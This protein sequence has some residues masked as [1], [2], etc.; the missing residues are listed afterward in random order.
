MSD[1]GY[2]T[3]RHEEPREESIRLSDLLALVERRLRLILTTA[4]LVVVG[5][6]VFLRLRAP[7]Y[8]A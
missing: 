3:S 4:V 5:T 7:L 6:F 2:G 1:H 8:R